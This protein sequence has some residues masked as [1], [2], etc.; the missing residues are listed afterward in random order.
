VITI[1]KSSN[2]TAGES[3]SLK[4]ELTLVA[5]TDTP[6]TTLLMGKGLIGSANGKIHTWRERSLDNTADIS[7]IEGSETTV[8]QESGRA[9]LNNVLEIFK[10]AAV[11][12][13]T[14]EAIKVPGQG[15]LFV[16]EI[17]DRMIEMKVNMEKQLINGVRNDGS[18]TPF[19]RRMDGLHK[20]VDPANVVNGGTLNV[21]SLAEVKNIA[22][23]LWD[24]GVATGE[25]YAM[26]NADLKEQIDDLY[27]DSYS[28]VHQVNS[29]GLVVDTIRT[30]YGN[31]N[32]ILN[33]HMPVD[34]ILAFDVNN[35]GIDFLRDPRFEAL[36]KTGDSTKG[37]VLSELTLRANTKK[38]VAQYKLKTS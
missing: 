17:Q 7:Q 13:G 33:R 20:W 14:A 23:K 37:H 31:L 36:S 10:K 32:F 2:L 35:L 26:V 9:E 24:Q 19:I 25:F 29:F 30:N 27:K 5:P 3:I 1:F 21:I 12:S 15:N 18:A 34:S 16:S 6:L 4:K 38:A 8:F 22:R 11:I 28:Y